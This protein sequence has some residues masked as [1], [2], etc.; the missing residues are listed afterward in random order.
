MLELPKTWYKENTNQEINLDVFLISLK[1]SK[2]RLLKQEEKIMQDIIM[3]E[4]ELW[5]YETFFNGDLDIDDLQDTVTRKLT[6]NIFE[7]NEKQKLYEYSNLANLSYI[8]LKTIKLNWKTEVS[9]NWIELDPLSFQNINTLFWNPNIASLSDD[10]KYLYEYIVNNKNIEPDYTITLNQKWEEIMKMAWLP[11]QILAQNDERYQSILSDANLG[12]FNEEISRKKAILI[13]WINSLIKAKEKDAEQNLEK[14][15]QEYKILDYYPNE[16]KWEKSESWFWATLL[17]KGWKKYI[18]IRGTEWLSDWWDLWADTKM[19]FWKIPNSQTKEMIKFIDRCKKEYFK[20][21]EKFVI[22]WHSLWWA[23]SQI[24]TAMYNNEVDETYTFNSPWA[25]NL[26]VS[27]E[28]RFKFAKINDFV[29]NKDSKQVS[30]LIT[31]VKWTDWISLISS[32]WEDIWTFKIELSWLSSH[33]INEMIKYIENLDDD[34]LEL[35]K[36]RTNEE[37]DKN[38]KR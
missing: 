34:S 3:E 7:N 12:N 23:L 5:I 33:S 17:E 4:Q 31:N 28:D 21:W 22:I 9:F 38:N 32:L 30:D 10:E 19:V 8:D 11:R 2:N 37:I 13:N 20:E 35:I 27:A 24:A 15:K 1:I 29:H 25:K 18:T 36:I 16:S 14:L 6:N 26:N